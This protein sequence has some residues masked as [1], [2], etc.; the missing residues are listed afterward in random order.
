[1]RNMPPGGQKPS[2][3]EKS[4]KPAAEKATPAPA[5]NVGEIPAPVLDVKEVEAA[6]NE[7]L[8]F[9]EQN[10]VMPGKKKRVV[11]AESETLVFKEAREKIKKQRLLNKVIKAD[12]KA[13]KKYARKIF[14][15]IKWWLIGIGAL[16]VLQGFLG[17]REISIAFH[18]FGSP[19][20]SSI[21]FELSDS[22]LLALIGGTTA[23]VIGLFAIVANYLFAKRPDE[24]E[25]EKKDSK[26]ARG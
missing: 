20:R 23:S 8:K 4:P 26:R 2:P 19:W 10:V 16:I 18:W 14:R 15:L 11:N 3:E 21:H 22:V 12:T 6:V 1:M 9:A 17:K 25:A 5:L 13:R 7:E 24:K